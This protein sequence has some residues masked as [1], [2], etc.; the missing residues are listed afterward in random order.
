MIHGLTET[1]LALQ[2][3]ARELAEAEFRPRAAE[4]DATEE[5]PWDSVKLLADAGLMGMTIQIGRAHV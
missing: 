4:V 2:A 3:A 1:Q 5:Y